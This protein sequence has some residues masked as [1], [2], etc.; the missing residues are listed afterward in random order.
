[1]VETRSFCA[2]RPS[3]IGALLVLVAEVEKGVAQVRIVDG[4]PNCV[5]TG[6]ALR[7]S[8]ERLQVALNQ[9][10]LITQRLTPL[11]PGMGF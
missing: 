1:M 7:L 8:N 10:G 4:V 11:A 3:R 6:H 2:T 5:L 9:T